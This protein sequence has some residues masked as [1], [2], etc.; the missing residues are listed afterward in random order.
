MITIENTTTDKNT[1]YGKAGRLAS[2]I[3]ALIL[4][5]CASTGGGDHD[6]KEMSSRE[7]LIDNGDD[8]CMTH[9]RPDR[10]TP[11]KSRL[12]SIIQDARQILQT[13]IVTEDNPIL[14]T[15]E[16]IRICIDDVL[17]PRIVGALRPF[18]T[19]EGD[20][21]DP[22]DDIDGVIEMNG[23]ND[24]DDLTLVLTQEIVHAYQSLSG[25]NP[26][27]TG[28]DKETRVRAVRLVEAHATAIQVSVAYGLRTQGNDD[29]FNAMLSFPGFEDLG[30]VYRRAR[31]RGHDV[32][33]ATD[34]TFRSFY[35]GEDRLKIYDDQTITTM[36]N[37][38]AL[39][40]LELDAPS[41]QEFAG[42]IEDLPQICHLFDAEDPSLSFNQ[43]LRLASRELTRR[44]NRLE[45]ISPEALSIMESQYEKGE[46][47]DYTPMDEFFVPNTGPA[48][49]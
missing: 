20:P 6:T 28:L 21:D 45:T 15:T 33:T 7:R 37:I 14:K 30:Q 46:R 31:D 4:A 40:Q 38:P 43:P 16:N 32:C 47:P 36:E 10:T 3:G 5:G 27:Q 12:T 25:A 35:N 34:D 48:P 18:L 13:G 49:R 9:D 39:R 26:W 44:F 29:I 17:E 24:D 41:I 19:D 2:G 23:V 1:F 11:E 42:N 8:I 22:G